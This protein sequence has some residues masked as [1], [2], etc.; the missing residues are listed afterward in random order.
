MANPLPTSVAKDAPAEPALKRA[1]EVVLLEIQGI[2]G[3]CKEKQLASHSLR[4]TKL[5]VLEQRL[6]I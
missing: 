5:F 6:G 2:I 4:W 1:L 3:A